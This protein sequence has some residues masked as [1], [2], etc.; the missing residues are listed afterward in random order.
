MDDRPRS[1]PR[2]ELKGDSYDQTTKET[3]D[4][5]KTKAQQQKTT[6]EKEFEI[7]GGGGTE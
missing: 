2:T 6:K 4:S 3:L 5:T 1:T 7:S